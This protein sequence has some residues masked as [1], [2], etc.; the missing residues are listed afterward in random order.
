MCRIAR[1]I[2]RRCCLYSDAPACTVTLV[3][4]QASGD[5]F[6]LSNHTDMDSEC[7]G[8]DSGRGASEEGDNVYATHG[9]VHPHPHGPYVR[10]E[11]A[12][13]FKNLH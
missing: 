2:P 6:N 3:L 9:A 7:S 11:P 13:A 1:D 10:K 5:V 8:T 12:G 4:L